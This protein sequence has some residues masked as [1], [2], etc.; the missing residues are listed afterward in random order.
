ME[1]QMQITDYR[2]NIDTIL[3][4][5]ETCPTYMLDEKELHAKTLLESL[6]LE[7]RSRNERT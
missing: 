1:V 5:M 4:Q 2:A 7:L 3:D 6:F